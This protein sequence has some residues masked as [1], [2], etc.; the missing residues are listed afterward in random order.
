MN[1]TT[2]RFIGVSKS[3]AEKAA[4]RRNSYTIAPQN[5]AAALWR[6]NIATNKTTGIQKVRAESHIPKLQLP[7]PCQLDW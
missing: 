1:N 4:E 6:L 7:E 2:D 3:K 5:T